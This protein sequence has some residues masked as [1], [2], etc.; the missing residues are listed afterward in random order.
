M[1]ARLAGRYQSLQV[2]IPTV[3]LVAEAIREETRGWRA[4]VTVVE[5]PRYKYDAFAACTV[6]LAASGT[7][8]LD[9]GTKPG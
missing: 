6:A 1:V 3:P 2:V 5:D 8:T 7:V 9:P 4:P